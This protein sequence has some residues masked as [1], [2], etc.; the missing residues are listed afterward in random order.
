[1]EIKLRPATPEAAAAI[2]EL[3]A[4]LAE[5][6]GEH[7]PLTA[8]YLPTFLAAPIN[9][10]LLA[11]V[12]GQVVGLLSYFIRPDLFHATDTCQIQELIVRS[13]FRGQQIGALLMDATMQHVSTLGCAEISVTTGRDNPGAIRFYR[14]HGFDYEAVYLEKHFN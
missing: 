12:A 8:D 7:S 13:G 11:E 4:E 3:V 2:V 1:M 6:A 14:R 5:S 10:V 9:H